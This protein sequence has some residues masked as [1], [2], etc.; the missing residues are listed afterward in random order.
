ME[1]R[2]RSHNGA[3]VTAR[4]PIEIKEQGN[5]VLKGI[6]ATPTELVNSAYMYVLKHREL[7]DAQ[8]FPADLAGK[9]RVLTADQKDVIRNRMRTTTF[10]VPASYWQGKTDDQ[11]LEEALREKYEAFA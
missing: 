3:V 8:P 4:V 1:A 6:G 7:P 11:L 9:K 5:A 10:A 2:T